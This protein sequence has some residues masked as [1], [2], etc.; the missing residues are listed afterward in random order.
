MLDGVAAIAA[1]GA[2]SIRALTARCQCDRARH[3]AAD[4]V[5]MA[6]QRRQELAFLRS[7]NYFTAIFVAVGIASSLKISVGPT[8]GFARRTRAR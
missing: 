1:L 8:R 6:R 7:G 5:T 3:A 2:L 4:D